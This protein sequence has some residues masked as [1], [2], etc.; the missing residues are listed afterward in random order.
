MDH[1]RINNINH[2]QAAEEWQCHQ[3][4][5]IELSITVGRMDDL[6]GLSNTTMLAYMSGARQR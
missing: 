3:I 4:K 5:P 1:Q 2:L 6:I